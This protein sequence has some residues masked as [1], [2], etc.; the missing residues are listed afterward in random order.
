MKANP[1]SLIQAHH[2]TLVD[3]RDGARHRPDYA[4]FYGLPAVVFVACLVF[5]LELPEGASQGLLTVAGLLSAFFFGV[6]LQVTERALQWADEKPEQNQSTS[7]QAEFLKQIAANA[8][9]ASLVSI[10]TAAVF[11]V[12]LLAKGTMLTASCALGLALALHLVLLLVMVMSW[13]YKMTA[14][15][16]DDVRTGTKATVT[17]FPARRAG[18][19]GS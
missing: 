5:G 3:D 2:R 19:N 13:V 8:G 15:R 16:L 7:W 12:A 9:Y 4:A 6:M 11:V 10:A 18:S 1:W 14:R 17:P